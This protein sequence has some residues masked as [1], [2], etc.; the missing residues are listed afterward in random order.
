MY[1]VITPNLRVIEQL[2]LD[3]KNM[4]DWNEMFAVIRSLEAYWLPETPKNLFEDFKE[5][6]SEA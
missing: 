1:M 5:R 3:F 4:T 2:L 6:R